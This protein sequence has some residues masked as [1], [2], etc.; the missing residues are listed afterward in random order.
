V[1][2]GPVFEEIAFR[3]IFIGFIFS[4]IEKKKFVQSK[5]FKIAHIILLSYIFAWSHF[6]KGAIPLI[7]IDSL[8][9]SLLYLVYK[10]NL[11]PSIVAHA[12]NNLIIVLYCNR[13]LFF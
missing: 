11:V 7:F 5:I 1:I 4:V 12:M 3:G 8:I 6:N 13:F 10:R 9:Y 2:I